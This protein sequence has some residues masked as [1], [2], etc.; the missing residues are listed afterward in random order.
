MP[1]SDGSAA[2]TSTA[3]LPLNFAD[4]IPSTLPSLT[5]KSFKMLRLRKNLVS[6]SKSVSDHAEIGRNEAFPLFCLFSRLSDH[7]TGVARG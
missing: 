1:K 6:D 7:Q 2:T 5:S 3:T 4:A